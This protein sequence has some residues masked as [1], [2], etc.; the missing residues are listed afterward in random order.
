MCPFLG[1]EYIRVN[2][3][4][5]Y[6]I[7]LGIRNSD[8]G[9]YQVFR[10]DPVT[11]PYIILALLNTT[12]C[13]SNTHWSVD[14]A[15]QCGDWHWDVKVSIKNFLRQGNDTFKGCLSKIQLL[16]DV[17]KFRGVA[18]LNVSTLLFIF[19]NTR[20]CA[21]LQAAD[22]GLLGQDTFQAGTFGGL[23]KSLALIS[24]WIV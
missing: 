6:L 7:F 2:I 13:L 17:F 10:T 9:G 4:P 12:R 19:C 15:M 24:N 21:V 18:C 5:I 3:S 22:L 8:V 1:I 16:N 20:L 14:H 11:A 23:S